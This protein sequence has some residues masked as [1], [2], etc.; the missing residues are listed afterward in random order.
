MTKSLSAVAFD[1][2]AVHEA[3]IIRD[4]V[5]RCCASGQLSWLTKNK[6]ELNFSIFEG[7][8]QA[9]A[10]ELKGYK[11]VSRHCA[12]QAYWHGR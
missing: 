2:E 12:L 8:Q 3:G 4:A 6:L 1:A 9:H 5:P 7:N 10:S 11:I